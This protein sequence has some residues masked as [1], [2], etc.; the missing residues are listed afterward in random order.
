MAEAER[1]DP[2]GDLIEVIAGFRHDPLGFVRYAFP[3]GE[4]GTELADETGPRPWQIET[5]NIIAEALT[6][7]DIEGA[8]RIATASGH[9]IGKSALVSWVILWGLATAPL[10]KVV[11]TANTG[12]Q[13]RTKTW[14]E[15]SKW[16][17]L[18][19][20]RHWFK[21]EATSI[22]RRNSSGSKEWRCDA[23]TWSENNT[24]A[25]AGLHNK[26]R[27][28][29]LL[30]DEAS[31]IADKVWEVAEGAL[32]DEDTEILWLVFGNPTENTGRFRECFAG[33]RFAHR[34]RPRQ[35][36]SRDV[37]GTNKREIDKWIADWGED[38][39][40]VR[41]RVKGEFPRGGSMQFIDGET[42]EAAMTREA[43]SHLRQPLVM[44][45]DVA[46]FGED[47]S[48]MT[49][50]RG[51][52]A[53]T[54]PTVKSRGLDLV[55]LSGKV[56]EQAMQHGARAIY[57]DEGGMG[58]GVVDMVRV[59]LPGRLVAGVNFGGKADRYMS[60]GDLP[61]V[62]DKAAEMWASMR[63]WLKTGAIENDPEL[64]AELTGR[65]YG[66]DT[67]NAIR[68]ER[69][70]DMKKR[71]L[72]SPDVADGLALTFAYPVADVPADQ[73]APALNPFSGLSVQSDYDPHADL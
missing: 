10:T 20:C 14:P 22:A 66:F 60:G 31:Q 55:T 58:A 28:I 67:H 32:T 17:N 5:L 24:A 45:V 56:A 52:D 7:D 41:V 40:F 16:F 72:S 23:A 63:L 61:L 59:M 69:K 19:I 49:F 37:P 62:A 71:G 11:I 43:V 57:I 1:R 27:R 4:P 8:L 12:D 35:I 36:D 29:L 53:R 2:E 47:Q 33:G 30:F 21:F 6:A 39:D 13:L 51:L 65:Q 64:K 54:I 38:S 34:W 44:G 73:P 70:E 68:L 25:F 3:W 18:L 26:G 15:V 48:V 50:R 46:R 9:G 42:V